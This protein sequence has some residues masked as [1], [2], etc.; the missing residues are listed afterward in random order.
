MHQSTRHGTFLV[1]LKPTSV[2]TD[3]DMLRYIYY[4]SAQ[5]K[6]NSPHQLDAS[7]SIYSTFFMS[8]RSV[9]FSLVGYSTQT[10]LHE[11]T[12]LSSTY[13]LVNRPSYL[14][15]CAPTQC[16]F[17]LTTDEMFAEYSALMVPLSSEC[18]NN[19]ASMMK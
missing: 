10:R 6:T 3:C 1:G 9:G 14:S 13:F 4:D 12:T 2:A 18:L 15:F 16:Y 8:V 5:R 7:K 11:Y 17:C 19:G